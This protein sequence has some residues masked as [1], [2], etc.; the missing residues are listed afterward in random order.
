[1]RGRDPEALEVHVMA[2]VLGGEA[3]WRVSVQ[4][5]TLSAPASHWL[6]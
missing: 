5:S 4:V 3:P 1:M 6:F 2:R